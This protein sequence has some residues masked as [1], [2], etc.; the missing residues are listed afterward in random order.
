M[1]FEDGTDIAK[2]LSALSKQAIIK[3][4]APIKFGV[5]DARNQKHLLDTVSQ[6]LPNDQQRIRTAAA[7]KRNSNSVSAT[8]TGNPAKRRKTTHRSSSPDQLLIPPT[9]ATLSFDDSKFL[10]V[11]SS[12]VVKQC[13]A[14]FIDCTGNCAL[15]TAVCIV[16]AREMAKTETQTM[17]VEA[18]PKR[19]LLVP[20]EPHGVH[21]YTSGLLLHSSAI[22]TT[23]G[24]EGAVCKE[25][26]S[27]LARGQLPRMAL[28]N[29]MWI[30]DI[31]FEL[32]V[33]TLP[34]QI[35]I[36]RHFPAANIVKLFPQKKG[37]QS[38][39]CA[40]RGNVSTYRLNTDEI[41]DMVKGNIM[42]NPSR[43]LAS[44]IGVTIIGPKNVREKILPGFL[45]VRRGRV[46]ATLIWLKANNP[47]YAD[48]IISD[49]HL[50][51][52]MENGVPNK[53]L[54][55]MR[56]SEDIEELEQE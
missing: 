52:I 10:R 23:A 39:N 3:A 19:H 32:S 33:L 51:E 30:G 7:V 13:I 45:W 14:N 42:P 54:N 20:S 16:C 55:I 53:R 2:D 9:D 34:E 8:N 56:H 46:R 21:Q 11:Q 44:T 50:D 6:L 17:L 43:I 29:G 36:A 31:P 49:Q 38:G 28:A 41:A 25:C 1:S 4:A 47:L 5:A 18:I 37:A 12:E 26:I 15:A 24:P 35:L 27:H 48:I 22:S 40:L